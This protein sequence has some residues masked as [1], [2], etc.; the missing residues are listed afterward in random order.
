MSDLAHDIPRRHAD[1]TYEAGIDRMAYDLCV[2]LTVQARR[3]AITMLCRS[4]GI[5][6]E[7]EIGHVRMR[8]GGKTWQFGV[9]HLSIIEQVVE[10]AIRQHQTAGPANAADAGAEQ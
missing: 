4:H 8:V 2:G 7:W 10:S 9:E 3:D 5:R 6:A 1:E